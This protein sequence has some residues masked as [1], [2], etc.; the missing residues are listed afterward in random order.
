MTVVLELDGDPHVL[1]AG[2][3]RV[4]ADATVTR[5]EADGTTFSLDADVVLFGAA[6][7]W[8]GLLPGQRAQVR[9]RAGVPRAGDDVVALL[10]ARA[11]PRL[12]GDPGRVQQAAGSLRAALADSARRVLEPPAAG[13][14]P[15]LVV[16]DT[17]ALDPVL[18]EDFR[19]AGLAHLTAVSGANVG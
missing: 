15:G 6:D 19:R 5:L 10:S 9:V 1:G 4:V 3:G 11:P 12:V 18:E 2:A 16:G 14:L 8:R 13:L 7:D 17:R